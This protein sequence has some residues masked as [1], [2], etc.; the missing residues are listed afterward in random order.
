MS[1]A[2]LLLRVGLAF[3][4]LYASISALISPKDWVWYVPEW[5]GKIL[6]A[7]ILLLIHSI[8]EL[9]I[10]IWL[11]VGW[12]G[13]FPATLAAMDILVI[14]LINLGIFSAV[15]RDVGLFFAALALVFLYRDHQYS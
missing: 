3:V 4:L 6:P 13:F 14:L 9:A 7:N 2:K 11:L 5:M 8:S 15:F 10:G 1:Q 12:K